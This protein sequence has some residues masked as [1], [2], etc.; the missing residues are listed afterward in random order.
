M[1]YLILYFML[2][3]LWCWGQS[4]N[5]PQ[6]S[7]AAAVNP[8][9]TPTAPA[10]ATHLVMVYGGVGCGYSQYLLK[11]FQPVANCPK[12]K[13][14]LLMDGSP[15]A[16]KTQMAEYLNR[17]PVYSNALLQHRLRKDSDIFPQVFV[18]DGE[19]EVLHIK[20]VKKGMLDKIKD[21]IGCSDQ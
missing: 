9:L 16:I 6:W 14:V 10:E 17:Y 15:E 18:F 12:A 13:V 3:P 19:K 21:K 2:M 11:N 1:R 5:L 8:E 20:G 4:T 7:A